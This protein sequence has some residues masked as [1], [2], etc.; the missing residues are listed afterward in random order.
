[1]ESLYMVAGADPE[2]MLVNP[3]GDLVSAIGIVPGTK[4]HP[5]QVKHGT[6]QWDNVMGE[7]NVTPSGTSEEFEENI[8]GALQDLDRIVSPNRLTVRASANFPESQLE[9][10]EAKIFGCDPDFN[11]WTLE[12]NT[13][14]GTATLENFRSAGGHFHIGYKE[15]TA[16]ML[17]DPFGKIEVVKMMDIFM[18]VPSVI[19]DRDPT[20]PTR[21]T[22]YGGAG[23]HR[24]KDYGVEYRTLGNYWISSP[25]LV[26]LMYTLADLAV[27]L[28]LDGES[29][30]IINKV[31]EKRVI[32]TIN[33]SRHRKARNIIKDI[34][35][36]L[37]PDIL[38]QL[39]E[40]PQGN[41]YSNWD[42]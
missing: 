15:S 1:M 34:S 22:L 10:E 18:G 8:R 40:K 32:E 2:L 28:T 31:G 37:P 42:L 41:L 17:N 23:A 38:T 6:V 20:A 25:K 19:L 14:D 30:T 29:E 26:H 36:Y 11:A 39:N 24:P 3:Q 33:G 13:V 21:R 5:H 35:K 4:E 7:F 9:V 16:E 12:M 27:G